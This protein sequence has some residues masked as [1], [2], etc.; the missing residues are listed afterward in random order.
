MKYI[1]FDASMGS[2][3]IKYDICLAN[4]KLYTSY[5]K[6]YGNK[7]SYMN[8][9]E[10]SGISSVFMERFSLKRL[11]LKDFHIKIGFLHYRLIAFFLILM[12]NPVL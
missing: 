7:K 4:K 11:L 2:Q 5:I 9:N 1:L 6:L 10:I 3:E 12:L 8:L